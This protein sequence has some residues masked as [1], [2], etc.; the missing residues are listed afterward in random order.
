[1]HKS[2]IA[3]LLIISV[4]FLGAGA[5]SA[6]APAFSAETDTQRFIG[7]WR[8]VNPD[9]LG[10]MIYDNVGNMAVQVMPLRERKKFAGAQPTPDE[11]KDA[12]TGYL[13]YFG[14]YTV[15]EA[16]HT[17]THHR[18]GSVNPGLVGQDAVRRYTFATDD[19]LI[20]VP[21]ESGNQIIW[22]RFKDHL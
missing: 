14:S 17:I 13:A 3:A 10:I 11:A 4:I 1:M 9:Q 12:I 19:R 16:A 2:A 8:A 18:K 20:L 15:D 22:E 7:S 6:Q 5:G 21:V